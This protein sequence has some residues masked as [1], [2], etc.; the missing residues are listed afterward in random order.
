MW[1]SPAAWTDPDRSAFGSLGV[2]LVP[3]GA[4]L[5]DGE[6]MKPDERPPGRADQVDHAD[7]DHADGSTLELNGSTGRDEASEPAFPEDLY[8]IPQEDRWFPG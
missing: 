6:S 7:V 2:F 5:S 8:A 3:N 4:W 1:R